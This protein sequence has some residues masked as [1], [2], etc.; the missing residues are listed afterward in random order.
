MNCNCIMQ[1]YLMKRNNFVR[2]VNICT[3]QLYYSVC[4]LYL[5]NELTFHYIFLY[6]YI[7]FNISVPYM[8]TSD[9]L[10]LIVASL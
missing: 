7:F 5:R 9:E 3:V 10:P 6:Y 8:D 1:Q 2:D 4:G